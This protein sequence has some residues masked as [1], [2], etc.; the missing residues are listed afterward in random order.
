MY[1]FLIRSVF[2]AGPIKSTYSRKFWSWS[3]ILQSSVEAIKSTKTNKQKHNHR[4]TEK[5]QYN[6]GKC[7]AQNNYSAAVR[8]LKEEDLENC[9]RKR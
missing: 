1:I 5:K 6:I 7:A 4:W 3:D 2:N 8:K 9:I